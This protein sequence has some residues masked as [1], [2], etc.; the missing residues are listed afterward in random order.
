LRSNAAPARHFKDVI[1]VGIVAH[2]GKRTT[3]RRDAVRRS[4]HER[5]RGRAHDIVAV[6]G[7]SGV[8]GD[9]QPDDRASRTF[10]AD[11]ETG[12]KRA[13]SFQSGVR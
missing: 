4:Q 10:A 9:G 12:F 2:N 3:E 6:I 8:A 5:A 1:A 11:D 13:R 7:E